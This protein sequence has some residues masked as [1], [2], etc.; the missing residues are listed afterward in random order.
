MKRN[1]TEVSHFRIS[2]PHHIYAC[3]ATISDLFFVSRVNKNTINAEVEPP[4]EPREVYI[5]RGQNVR[6]KFVL[7]QEIG[8]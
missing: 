2:L 1:R 6:D 4:F 5:R 8:R 7:E 3:S